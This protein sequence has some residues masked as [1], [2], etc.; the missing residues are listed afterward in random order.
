[1]DKFHGK[2]YPF[3]IGH[4]GSARKAPENTLASFLRAKQDGFSW[5]EFDVTLARGGTP[6][7]FHDETLERTTDG[8]GRLEDQAIESLKKLSAGSWFSD[9]Y[10]HERIPKLDEALMLI[11]Q[12]GMGFNMELKPVDGRER[13]T[14][15]AAIFL[16]QAAWNEKADLPLISSFSRLAILSA[17]EIAPNWPRSLLFEKVE[18]DWKEIGKSLNLHSFGMDDACVTR[19]IIQKIKSEGYGVMVYTVN[20]LERAKLLR[21]WGVDSIFTDSPTLLQAI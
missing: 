21:G 16:A 2:K 17:Y 6:V 20:E 15:E 9:N 3:L 4:R 10:S 8:N 18:D 7:V 12:L 19:E 1:M 5:V 14:A 11:G 13:E